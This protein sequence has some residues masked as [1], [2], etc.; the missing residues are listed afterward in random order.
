[1]QRLVL[2]DTLQLVHSSSAYPGMRKLV[3]NLRM[4]GLYAE[5]GPQACFQLVHT[6]SAVKRGT[7]LNEGRGAHLMVAAVLAV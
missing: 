2:R 7:A 1:M 5:A 3:V 4:R 6:L